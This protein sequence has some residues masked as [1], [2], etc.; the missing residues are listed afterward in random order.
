M[1]GIPRSVETKSSKL[2]E[3]ED[4]KST[5]KDTAVRG[6]KAVHLVLEGATRICNALVATHEC[7]C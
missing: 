3:L 6:G 4:E 7:H 1:R 2:T 5:S